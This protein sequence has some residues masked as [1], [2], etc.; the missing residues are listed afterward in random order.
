[1]PPTAESLE[2]ILASFDQEEI[3]SMFGFEGPSR[4]LMEERRA[5]GNLIL[6]VIHKV[7][8]SE[9]I[10]FAVEFPPV[11]PLMM[12]EFGIAIPDPRHRD[13]KSAIEAGDAWA[14]YFFD[15]LRIEEGAWRTRADNSASIAL[16]T[17]MGYRPYLIWDI[18]GVKQQFF[19]MDKAR[20]A[21]RLALIQ[22]EEELHPTGEDVFTTL[23]AP[24]EPV[25]AE[26]W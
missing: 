22:K 26:G 1:M 9:R 23:E 4:A 19:R 6:G 15:H 21:E 7:E 25:R 13:L 8:T 18:G 3:W 17:R 5:N 10:G 24:F 12:W 16:A 11:P 2:W 14:H 20:W